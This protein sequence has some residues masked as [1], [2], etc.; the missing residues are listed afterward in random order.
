MVDSYTVSSAEI[1]SI[2][3]E[4]NNKAVVLGSQT[5]GKGTT[6]KVVRLPNLA[7]L[8][9]TNAKFYSPSGYPMQNA[10][11][12]TPFCLSST[13]RLNRIYPKKDIETIYQ[14]GKVLTKIVTNKKL[15]EKDPLKTFKTLCPA[16]RRKNNKDDIRIAKQILLNP[17][18]YKKYLNL[19]QILSS[20]FYQNSHIYVK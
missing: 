7:E 3:L 1:L 19:T 9:F 12:W 13:S 10:G 20:Y 6:Q 4:E 17:D 2:A 11:V 16:E 14:K 5:Y 15:N 18:Y 8:I